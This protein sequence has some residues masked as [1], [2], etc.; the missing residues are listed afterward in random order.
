MA[1]TL[2]KDKRTTETAEFAQPADLGFSN[3]LG[4]LMRARRRMQFESGLAPA[5][6]DRLVRLMTG[7]A[8]PRGAGEQ[9]EG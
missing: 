1:M 6:P 9:G 7:R 2:V 3:G 5:I 4:H 8:V